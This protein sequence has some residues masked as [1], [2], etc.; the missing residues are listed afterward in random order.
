M[1]PLP[2][3]TVVVFTLS[4]FGSKISSHVPTQSRKLSSHDEEKIILSSANQ[5]GF[6]LFPLLLA[7]GLF[8]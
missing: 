2:G 8:P 5:N 7:L 1:V 6:S 3:G 4:Y